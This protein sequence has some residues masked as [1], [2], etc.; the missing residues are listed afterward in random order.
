MSS[1]GGNRG[2]AFFAGR[3]VADVERSRTRLLP[4]ATKEIRTAL[5]RVRA[6]SE[7]LDGLV[8]DPAVAN[9]KRDARTL[10]RVLGPLRDADVFRALIAEVFDDKAPRPLVAELT[11]ERRAFA[12]AA[13]E[14]VRAFDVVAFSALAATVAERARV[15]EGDHPV[16]AHVARERLE[17]CR[18]LLAE[19]RARIDVEEPLHALRIGLKRFRYVIESFLPAVHAQIAKRLKTV[20][21]VL[22]TIHDLDVLRARVASCAGLT[23]RARK[24]ALAR[25]QRRRARALA[26]FLSLSRTGLLRPFTLAMPRHAALTDVA[27]ARAALPRAALASSVE[28]ADRVRW[29]CDVVLDALTRAGLIDADART[30]QVARVAARHVGAEPRA[31][32][33]SR[34]IADKGVLIGLDDAFLDDAARLA[35]RAPGKRAARAA[36]RDHSDE[37]V[38]L[39]ASLSLARALELTRAGPRVLR[40]RVEFDTL[41]VEVEGGEAGRVSE[42]VRRALRAAC[43]LALLVV[44]RVPFVDAANDRRDDGERATPL[45]APLVPDEP[46][47]SANTP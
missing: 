29:T 37:G 7:I 11:R 26:R 2:I 34:A 10:M 6:M 12:H 32:R 35:R 9:L 24:N 5:R 19:A 20:Q 47:A 30:R 33:A 13:R 25:V 28:R 27:V 42:A 43:G 3:A 46:R 39:A 1:S 31:R 45:R 4:R 8:D 18:P 36:T 40:A 17:E 38:V 41:V 15:F 22:G 23:P 16:M 14:A 21:D 44:W